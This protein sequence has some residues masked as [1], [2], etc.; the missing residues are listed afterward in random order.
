MDTE[1][2]RGEQQPLFNRGNA[3]KFKYNAMAF[4]VFNAIFAVLL[5]I[6]S[7]MRW[8][9]LSRR[10]NLFQF[11]SVA[12]LAPLLIP[13]AAYSARHLTKKLTSG[14]E[15]HKEIM[16]TIWLGLNC[17]LGVCYIILLTVVEQ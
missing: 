14:A 16:W 9:K 5:I 6:D 15:Y 3:L 17:L 4:T 11:I 12:I 8:D 1:S 13:Y 2:G 7:M 10:I